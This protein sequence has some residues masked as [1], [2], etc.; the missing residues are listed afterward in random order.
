MTDPR[1]P[2]FPWTAPSTIDS[3]AKG[4]VAELVLFAND[5]Q[6]KWSLVVAPGAKNVRVPSLPSPAADDWLGPPASPFSVS[7][8]SILFVDGAALA[9]YTAFRAQAGLV[10]S[11]SARLLF[12]GIPNGSFRV[13][14]W[15][16]PRGS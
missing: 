3:T 15:V 9:S 7:Q 16:E 4:G 13:T 11:P 12:A 8:S 2:F 14:R 5:R 1:R 6:V 10:F